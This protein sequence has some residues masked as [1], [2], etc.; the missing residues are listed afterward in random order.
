MIVIGF[1]MAMF[2]SLIMKIGS[3]EVVKMKKW[4]DSVLKTVKFPLKITKNP[5]IS[6]HARAAATA[7][8]ARQ[9]RVQVVCKWCASGVQN[10]LN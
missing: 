2:V 6:L 5:C 10:R 9:F 8:A 4:C 1:I 7:Y 3:Q